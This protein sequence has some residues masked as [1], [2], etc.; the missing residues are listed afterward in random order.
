M[1]WGVNG[2]GAELQRPQQVFQLPEVEDV[3]GDVFAP[4]GLGY[5][6]DVV[7]VSLLSVRCVSFRLPQ[8][9][10]RALLRMKNRTVCSERSGFGTRPTKIRISESMSNL[11]EHCRT[12]VSSTKSKIRISEGKSKLVCVLPRPEYLRR[13]PKIRN[14]SAL[15]GVIE[16]AL[17]D[18]LRFEEVALRLQQVAQLE[19]HRA[20]LVE[21]R[22]VEHTG[23]RTPL[24]GGVEPPQLALDRVRNGLEKT[25]AHREHQVDSPKSLVVSMALMRR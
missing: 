2:F 9:V 24:A 14:D 7:F 8:H 17:D 6:H 5:I 22:Q 3:F 18:A 16:P 21:D 4:F 19:H 1:S 12:G 15:F 25:V 10:R 13:Q 11:F 20:R 23:F